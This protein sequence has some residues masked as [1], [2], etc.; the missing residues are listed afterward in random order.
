[1]NSTKLTLVILSFIL[2]LGTM[3]VRTRPLA[4]Q[5]RSGNPIVVTDAD[6]IREEATVQ[7]I[8]LEEEIDGV[9][10]RVVLRFVN[11]LQE[12]RLVSIPPELEEQLDAVEP[13]VVLRFV[14]TRQ[15]YPL[16]A[17]PSGLETLLENVEDRIVLRFVNSRREEQLT[18][19][20]GLLDDGEPP[21]LVGEPVI[22]QA[23]GSPT[24]Q[25]TSNE[26][27][28]SNLEYGTQPGNYSDS[29]S[30]PLLTTEHA[31]SFSG[32]D[33]TTYYFR[34]TSTDAC[35]NTFTSQEYSIEIV[36]EDNTLYTLYLPAILRQ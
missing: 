30:D 16:H 23:G 29:I 14:N 24:V 7:S 26:V 22:S 20:C 10:M 27:G 25:W 34:F 6:T 33:G 13:G 17:I 36:K 19:P 5:S 1:M 28:S 3:L 18:F 31:I 9:G 35:G 15:E 4:G 11:T 8:P 32:T 12:Y 2:V 21:Q